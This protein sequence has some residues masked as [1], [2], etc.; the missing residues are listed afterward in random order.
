MLLQAKIV[1][2]RNRSGDALC[3]RCSGAPPKSPA[4]PADV[5]SLLC[6]VE[7]P[8]LGLDA[9]PQEA[10]PPVTPAEVGLYVFRQP[11]FR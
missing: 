8:S 2:E 4:V 3:S 7:S 5:H 9:V 6:V 11:G 1:H 10:D